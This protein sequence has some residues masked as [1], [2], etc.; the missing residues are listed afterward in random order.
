MINFKNCLRNTVLSIAA[1]LIAGCAKSNLDKTPETDKVLTSFYKNEAQINEGV[2]GAYA[3]LQNAGQYGANY[4]VFGE[5]PSDNTFDEVPANDG[6]NYG[7]LDL[8]SA[9]ALNSLVDA[10]WK[11]AY[12]GIQQCNIILNRI[13]NIEMAPVSKD[14]VKGEML[15]I[16][17][18]TYFNLVR[19]FGDVPLVIKETTNVNDYFGQ[20]RTAK[21]DVYN[22]IEQDL[23]RAIQLLPASRSLNGR[24][25]QGAA[26]G[27]L[28]KV[29][30]TLKKYDQA[31]T[32]LQKIGPL[33]YKLLTD[34]TRIFNPAFKNNE[35]IIFDVQFAS[36]I[37]GNAE[38]SNAFQ[39]FSPSGTVAGAKGHNLPTRDVYN[40]FTEKDLRKNAYLGMT[41]DGVPFT[42]KLVQTSS[43]VE[44]GGSNIVVLRYADVLLM[45]AECYN[46]TGNAAK[47]LENLNL[48]RDR[49]G[50]A[51]VVQTDPAILRPV[52]AQERRLE[53]VTE[54]SRWF[55]L[56]RTDSAIE[57]MNSYF[58]RTP[59]YQ[60]VKI[61]E[62]N[63]VQPIPQ[64]QTNTDPA[65]QQ[66]KGY[67]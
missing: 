56:I 24:V 21:A 20:G 2:N 7:Q 4:L 17:A 36:G 5:I 51:Q 42:R 8:F 19:I 6:G 63:L 52:I 64:S 22:Q 66:N 14:K 60:G 59:G 11:D 65:I 54:G 67:N 34:L 33:G 46:E 31:I 26:V 9:I 37:N 53:L 41:K 12:K 55:D 28:G 61:N 13:D 48:V 44:D 25:T 16:R 58:A 39:L 29:Y 18:L 40:S 15:F 50:I 1:F 62:N 23:T 35:E 38:G 43:T 45:L 30:L 3:M 47:S 57:V 27:L 32:Q 49:A 10:T